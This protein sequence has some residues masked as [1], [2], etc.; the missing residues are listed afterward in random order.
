MFVQKTPT[1]R[2]QQYDILLACTLPFF[3]S[4]DTRA[5]SSSFTHHSPSGFLPERD[6]SLHKTSCHRG[7]PQPTVRSARSPVQNRSNNNQRY[8]SK[9]IHVQTEPT[10]LLLTHQPIG[11]ASAPPAAYPDLA[12]APPFSPLQCSWLHLQTTNT[13]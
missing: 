1:S 12:L 9:G 10:A 8:P 11:P 13:D 2:A 6:R 5:P 4:I 7:T 3:E